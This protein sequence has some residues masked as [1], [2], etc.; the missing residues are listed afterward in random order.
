MSVEKKERKI[1]VYC[2]RCSKLIRYETQTESIVGNA[3]FDLCDECRRNEYKPKVDELTLA[4]DSFHN[5]VTVRLNDYNRIFLTIC[6][7]MILL[8]YSSVLYDVFHVIS[9]DDYDKIR[10]AVKKRFDEVKRI[11]AGLINIEL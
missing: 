4:L 6:E 3:L 7:L 11:V 5:S 1:P 8:N 9:V 2:W 10:E